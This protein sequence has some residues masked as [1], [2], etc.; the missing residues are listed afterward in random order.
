M[1]TAPQ[2]LTVRRPPVP[3][4][5]HGIVAVL[6][7]LFLAGFGC[8][9][10]TFEQ[11]VARAAIIFVG[12]ATASTRKAGP[13]LRVTWFRIVKVYKGSLK[14][15][16]VFKRPRGRYIKLRHCIGPKCA[17]SF[18]S[19]RTYLV[20]AFTSGRQIHDFGFCG[21]IVREWP[22]CRNGRC[23]A[24]RSAFLKK[25]KAAIRKSATR[26]RPASGRRAPGRPAARPRPRPRGR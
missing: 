21:S 25:L 19:G 6:L 5:A 9:S 16:E 18:S 3:C 4:P 26:P 22:E 1:I 20:S 14:G 12:K 15:L 13:D 7:L 23:R 17:G 24:A 11:E 10:R 8:P 2:G